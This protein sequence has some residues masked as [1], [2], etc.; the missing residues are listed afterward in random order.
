MENS[1]PGRMALEAQGAARGTAGGGRPAAPRHEERPA[2]PP[3][4]CLVGPLL[5]NMAVASCESQR[6]MGV[7]AA[8]SPILEMRK[9]SHREV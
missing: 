4:P 7:G 6:L 3:H 1:E 9:L 8:V 5:G 2:L